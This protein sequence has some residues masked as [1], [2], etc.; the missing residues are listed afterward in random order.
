MLGAGPTGLATAHFHGENTVVLEAE[1]RVGGLCRSLEFGGA[2]FD[3]GGHSFHTPHA[4]IHQFVVDLMAG[5][6]E[7]QTRDARIFSHGRMIPYPFQKHFD[8]LPDPVAVRECREGL[9]LARKDARADNF[10]DWIVHRFGPGVARHFMWPYNRKLWARDLRTIST[11]W[12]GQRIAGAKGEVERFVR[13][14]GPRRPLQSDTEVGYPSEGGFETLFQRL[15]AVTPGIEVD[16]RVERI[17]PV[18]RI[19]WTS[20]GTAYQWHR[21][22]STIPLDHLVERV[23]GFPT[24]LREEVQSLAYMSLDLLLLRT[25]IAL[26]KAPQRIYFADPSVPPHKV[27]FNHTSSLQLRRRPCHAIM[28]EISYSPTKPKLAPE[29][30]EVATVS[31]LVHAGVLPS[32]K[33]VA[34]VRHLDIRHAYPVYTHERPGILERVRRHLEAFDIHIAGRFGEWEY[35]NSDECLRKGRDLE[36][37]VLA[38]AVRPQHS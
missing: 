36:R 8:Q 18:A 23:D 25:S 10:E 32:A 24:G 1:N 37:L 13:D 27:A 33:V 14:D 30:A 29:V 4:S 3:I 26:P 34:E 21:L 17:D 12:V 2:V 15:A 22:V 31:A 6:L 38:R 28:A 7:L 19:A 5:D 20:D 16:K 35:V 9:A 11:E